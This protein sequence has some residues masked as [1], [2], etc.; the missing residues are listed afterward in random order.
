MNVYFLLIACLQLFPQIS[1]VN[2]LSTWAALVFIFAISA[3]RE[4]VDDWSRFKEDQKFNSRKYHVVRD[5][6]RVPV[7]S[8]EIRVGDIVY[9]QENQEVWLLIPVQLTQLALGVLVLRPSSLQT[10]HLS[11]SGTPTHFFPF[12]SSPPSS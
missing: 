5:G 7:I 9:L 4:A 8:E 12:S 10:L 6:F 1:P 2:P 3:I 11:L